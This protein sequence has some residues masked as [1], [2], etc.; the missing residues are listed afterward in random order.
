MLIDF[1]LPQHLI[2]THPSEKRDGCKMLV[3]DRGTQQITHTVFNQLPSI[4][5]PN[6]LLVLNQARVNPS[7]M[8]WMDSKGKK[9]E[10]VFL[11]PLDEYSWEA[12]VSGKKL[13]IDQVYDAEEF[14]FTITARSGTVATISLNR[15]RLE[16]ESILQN[17]A[18]LPLPPYIL[19]QRRQEGE[20]EYET[21]DD[22][23]YQTVFAKTGGAVAA[24]TA[25]LHFT[26]QTFSDLKNTGI[27]WEYVHL[28]VGWGTFAPLTSE[29]FE[30]KTLH[31]EYCSISS[32]VSRKILQAKQ[33]GKKVLAIGTTSVRT[34]ES[35]ARAGVSPS[36]FASNTDIFITPPYN[37]QIVDAMLTNFHIPQS[38][39][40]LLVAAF[41]GKEGEKKI[42]DVYR[43]AIEQQ[44]RFYSY[45]DCML[46]V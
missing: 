31:Q 41:L 7:R 34:L 20:A 32:Q 42:L 23:D 24:P 21:S 45:G 30:T 6:H 1:E 17:K 11:K 39:L 15:S 9:Q 10:I 25:G 13:K 33:D 2:A 18:Q 14:E 43:E 37:F 26:D 36:G 5:S 35:W 28:S 22:Q 4:L 29:N 8:F 38:S 3:F 46:I 16:I 44:Y 40:L 12:I 19:N 27:D